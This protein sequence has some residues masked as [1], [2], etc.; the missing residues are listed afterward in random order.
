MGKLRFLVLEGI[1]IV[2]I[3]EK[4]FSTRDPFRMQNSN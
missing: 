4:N 2:I 3:L 1:L